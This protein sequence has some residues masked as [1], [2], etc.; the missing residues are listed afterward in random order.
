MTEAL[1]S[2]TIDF[3]AIRKNYN[4]LTVHKKT[5]M[6]VVKSDAYGHGVFEVSSALQEEG[7]KY[8][9]VG[10]VREAVLLR[11]SGITGTIVPLL[12]CMKKEEYELSAV[13]KIC[14]V[15]HNVETLD[16][17]LDY[18]LDI[19]IKIDTG[20]GRLGFRAKD[21]EWVAQ[22]FKGKK[23]RPVMLLSHFSSAYSD[24]DSEYTEIQASR[25]KRAVDILKD[26]YP[27][28]L[29]SF[30][31]SATI[32]AF[33]EIAGDIVRPG[34]LLYGGNP[35]YATK[36]ESLGT[37]FHPAMSLSAPVL[38]VQ[39]LNKGD[40]VSYGTSFT[41]K[42]DSVVAWIG[43]GYADGYRINTK[44]N[45]EFGHGGAQVVIHNTRCPIIGR[46]TMQMTAIDVTDL[47]KKHEVTTGQNAYLLNGCENGIRLEELAFWWDTIPYEVTTMLGKNLY[48]FQD[49]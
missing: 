23:A 43:M 3:E 29:T 17:S 12:G 48:R 13:Y 46:V 2:I 14:T 9:A 16:L 15:V 35:F 39:K 30:G 4:L 7:A 40:R 47:V 25:M 18:D 1:C 41:A 5:I 27:D 21:M 44:A 11:K 32:L 24:D 36:Q 49:N 42:R 33:P 26:T 38:S 10:T 28:I 20:M 22:K 34:I 45:D 37:A 6:P 8:F 19:A 31:N